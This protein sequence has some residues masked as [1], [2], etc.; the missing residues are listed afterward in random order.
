MSRDEVHDVSFGC[1]LV[2]LLPIDLALK[3]LRGASDTLKRRVQYSL[4]FLHMIV[5]DGV[6]GIRKLLRELVHRYRISEV[7]REE[8]C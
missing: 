1:C 5:A 3:H 2:D 6:H 4:G 8:L 7:W